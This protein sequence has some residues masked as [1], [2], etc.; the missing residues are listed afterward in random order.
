MPKII[1]SADLFG[2]GSPPKERKV[3]SSADLFGSPAPQAEPVEATPTP[4][5]TK[6]SSGVTRDF[7]EETPTLRDAVY[8][9]EAALPEDASPGRAEASHLGDVGSLVGRL[10]TAL[11]KSGVKD[12]NDVDLDEESKLTLKE[13]FGRD[14]GEFKKELAKKAATEGGIGGFIENVVRDPAT[15]FTGGLS[16]TAPVKGFVKNV[17]AGAAEGGVSALAHQAEN[18]AEGKKI[19]VG[20]AIAETALGAGTR[21]LFSAVGAGLRKLTGKPA[22]QLAK[23]IV[24]QLTD[25]PEDVLERASDPKQM[26][27]IKKAVVSTG[28]DL[29]ALGDDVTAMIDDSRQK[30]QEELNT[31]IM[32]ARPGGAIPP[33]EATGYAAGERIADAAERAKA[34]TGERFQAAQDIAL[35]TSGAGKRP[36][37]GA[38]AEALVPAGN[39]PG[40]ILQNKVDEVLTDIGYDPVKGFTGREKVGNRA[41]GKKAVELLNNAKEMFGNAQNTEDA[42]NMRRQIQKEIAFGGPD[43]RPLFNKGSDEDLV[44]KKLYGKINEVVES[45]IQAQADELGIPQDIVGLWKINNEAWK[46]SNDA[47]KNI[48][49]KVRIGKGNTE[50]YFNSVKKIGIDKLKEMSDIAAKD[51]EM[52]PV[53]REIQNGYFD[54]MVNR[55]TK[56]GNIDITAFKKAW[57][58]MDPGFKKVMLGQEKIA[59]INEAIEKADAYGA[60]DIKSI[61]KKVTGT[62]GTSTV[63][64]LENIGEKSKRQA[65]KELIFLEDIAGVPEAERLSKT[66]S[67]FFAGKKLNLTKEGSLRLLSGSKTGKFLAG[68]AAGTAA[69]GSLGRAVAGTPGAALGGAAGLLAGVFSQSPSGG[70]AAYKAVSKLYG[71]LGNKGLRKTAAA[72]GR[73]AGGPEARQAIRSNV[74]GYDYENE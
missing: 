22:E 20:S 48:Q 19:D 33:K 69:G 71:I 32:S 38:A 24:S 10:V 6:I 9:R 12:I 66:A 47:L 56:E 36:L 62:G 42:L 73:V 54:S 2:T 16:G 51:P 74:F 65:L 14:W 44:M 29:T 43:G 27:A 57:D 8:P 3:V 21:G 23:G 59:T 39:S 60:K 72:A 37:P 11:V 58:K 55:S 30:A 70:L 41:I 53:W 68:G 40:N 26:E 17:I 49:N 50:E 4:E 63:K 61:G 15:F 46:K 67:D 31:G 34:R 45:Q 1:S 5:P 7:G 35:E 52:A 28:G 13:K 18:V 64:N 25:I